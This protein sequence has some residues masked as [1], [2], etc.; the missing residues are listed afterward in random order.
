MRFLLDNNISPRVIP[1]LCASRHDAVHVRDI[2]LGAADDERVF[3]IAAQ[4]NRVL[5]SQDTDFG[6]LLATRQRKQP[7]LILFRRREKSAERLQSLLLELLPR[8]RADLE[9]GSVVVVE[10]AR[11]RVRRLPILP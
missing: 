10:D 8:V 5:L 7:S 4:Q 6:S 11:I 3:D 9:S 2:G 1:A